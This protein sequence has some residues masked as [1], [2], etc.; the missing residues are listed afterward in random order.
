MPRFLGLILLILALALWP[1]GT[2]AESGQPPTEAPRWLA[3]S[4]PKDGETPCPD[5]ASI[6]RPVAPAE[7]IQLPILMYH[8]LAHLSANASALWR[9][10]TVTPE[11]FE[12]QVR[13]LAEHGYHTIYFAD[14]I[15]YWDEGTPLPEQP[16]ILTFDDGWLEGY[17]VAYP[18]LRKYCMVGTFFPPVNW[19][20]NDNGKRVLSWPMI[21]EMSRGGMEFGSHTLNH[22]LLARQTAPQILEQL[23]GSKAALEKHTIRPVVALAYPG[24]SYNALVLETVPKAGYGA[25]VGVLAGIE[26]TRAG[27]FALRRIAMSYNDNLALFQARLS[28]S[29]STQ[30][31]GGRPAR[32]P[33]WPWHREETSDR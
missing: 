33:R 8:H 29:T 20:D 5:R 17:T 16:I 28:N 15:A 7:T 21:E 3:S 31:A 1:A 30:T 23:V 22:H 12:A 13:Y 14:L 32:P 25:A 4:R 9:S 6:P 10:L 24:G 11:M 2:R 18:I 26:Q 27:R 19:V